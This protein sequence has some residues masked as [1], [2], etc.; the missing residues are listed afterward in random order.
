M[1][2]FR[3]KTVYNS[4][5][6]RPGEERGTERKAQGCSHAGKRAAWIRVLIQSRKRG[7]RA[8]PSAAEMLVCDVSRGSRGSP[9]PASPAQEASFKLLKTNTGGV[10][11][12]QQ[13]PQLRRQETQAVG[14]PGLST[15]P[16]RG[17]KPACAVRHTRP[18]PPLSSGPS[19]SANVTAFEKRRTCP[20]WTPCGRPPGNDTQ[21]AKQEDALSIAP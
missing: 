17:S 16:G 8:P 4:D 1:A 15:E 10:S 20:P 5:M 12:R 3:R 7:C 11:H 6:E 21:R 19:W 2:D 14:N 9:G 18:S 13:K